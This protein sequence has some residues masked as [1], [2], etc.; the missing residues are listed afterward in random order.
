MLAVLAG[1]DTSDPD[2]AALGNLLYTLFVVERAQIDPQSVIDRDAALAMRLAPVLAD[3]RPPA[4]HSAPRPARAAG[5]RRSGT[6]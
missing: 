6:A 2:Q 4:A 3:E 5:R 1:L